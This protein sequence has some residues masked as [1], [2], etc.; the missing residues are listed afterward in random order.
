MNCVSVPVF[1]FNSIINYLYK[2]NH[3]EIYEVYKCLYELAITG[4]LV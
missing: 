4:W 2:K 1:S 3:S